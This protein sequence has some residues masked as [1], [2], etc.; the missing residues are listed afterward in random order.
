MNIY[1]YTMRP[2]RVGSQKIILP[3]QIDYDDLNILDK[4]YSI[5]C[6][7]SAKER[8]LQTRDIQ[9]DYYASAEKIRMEF[10]DCD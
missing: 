1:A 4:P 8:K 7:N 6:I 10:L 9:E 5:Y 2:K 3:Y